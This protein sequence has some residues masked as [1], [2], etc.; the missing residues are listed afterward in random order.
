[1]E[2]RDF[3]GIS[4]VL[5]NIFVWIVIGM[6]IWKSRPISNYTYNVDRD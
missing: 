4:L 1:M 3:L 6:I 5:L 2:K